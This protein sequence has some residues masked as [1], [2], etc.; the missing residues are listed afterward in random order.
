MTLYAIRH[1]PT[2]K[3][4]TFYTDV[5]VSSSPKEGERHD[6]VFLEAEGC[7][8][9]GKH[10]RH[11]VLA[12]DDVNLLHRLIRTGWAEDFKYNAMH[13]NLNEWPTPIPKEDLEIVTLVIAGDPIA[14][15]QQPEDWERI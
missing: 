15:N 1:K 2:G 8:N 9:V 10:N 12:V 14:W 4:L 13:L 11:V 6:R 5:W 3:L 7:L